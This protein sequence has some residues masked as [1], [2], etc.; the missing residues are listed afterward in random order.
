MNML[1]T[2]RLSKLPKG[3]S[4]PKT[5]AWWEP[6]NNYL[7]VGATKKLPFGGSL[8]WRLVYDGSYQKLSW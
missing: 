8:S 4:L 7:M 6:P 2:R 3:G 1:L 5:I